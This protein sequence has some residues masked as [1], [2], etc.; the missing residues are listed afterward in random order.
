M[1]STL[2]LLE[3]DFLHKRDSY[4]VPYWNACFKHR[5]KI[6]KYV[7]CTHLPTAL[8][9]FSEK[10][11]F[12][13]WVYG[14]SIRWLRNRQDLVDAVRFTVVSTKQRYF[15]FWSVS[16]SNM[17]LW[18]KLLVQVIFYQNSIAINRA[19]VSTGAWH[20]PKF[21]TSPPAPTDFKVL[22]TNWH[23]Q[24]SFYVTSGTLSFKFQTQALI[25]ILSTQ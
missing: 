19:W 1:I 16:G 18:S 20:P 8:V 17:N 3:T 15:K 4:I 6:D 9:V 25:K 11:L 21:R 22:N 2:S 24:S 23:P 5:P 14:Y 7:H 12:G 13:I 10:I